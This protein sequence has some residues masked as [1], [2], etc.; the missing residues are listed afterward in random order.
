M[1]TDARVASSSPARLSSSGLG[2]AASHLR[3]H[4]VSCVVRSDSELDVDGDQG[5]SQRRTGMP[6]YQKRENRDYI[7]LSNAPF[8]TIHQQRVN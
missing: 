4:A 5:N 2:Q 7:I 3:H 8:L 1:S 6:T